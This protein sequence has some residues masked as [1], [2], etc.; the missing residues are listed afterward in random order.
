MMTFQTS[1]SV[2][3]GLK[4]RRGEDITG[5][6]PGR[7][8]CISKPR[9]S[10]TPGK[11]PRFPPGSAC[12]LTHNCTS[13]T[14]P[15]APLEHEVQNRPSDHGSRQ[16]REEARGRHAADAVLQVVVCPVQH[17]LIAERVAK[18]RAEVGQAGLKTAIAQLRLH[19]EPGLAVPGHQEK[20]C[21]AMVVFSTCRGPPTNTIFCLRS[22]MIAAW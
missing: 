18:P 1:N 21:L 3:A 10:P 2:F 4:S 5:W 11:K 17:D 22:A 12:W 9:A 13:S 20:T 14:K 16:C 19:R 6:P 7:P 15:W 8:G